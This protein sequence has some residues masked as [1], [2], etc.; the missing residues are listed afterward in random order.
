[1][2]YVCETLGRDLQPVRQD[3]SRQ[4][5]LGEMIAPVLPASDGRVAMMSHSSS[6]EQRVKIPPGFLSC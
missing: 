4:D 2:M 3:L 5:V 1:M 6:Y